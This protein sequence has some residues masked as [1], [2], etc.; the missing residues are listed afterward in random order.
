MRKDPVRRAAQRAH[1][2]RE[3]AAVTALIKYWYL[4]AI[5]G[6]VLALAAAAVRLADE[7]AAHAKTKQGH[8][9]VLRDLADKTAAAYQA[10]LADQRVHKDRLAEL[11]ARHTKELED[12][13]RKIDIA[14]SDVRAGRSRLRV[15]AT[16][17][18]ATADVPPAAGATGM[19]DAA[20]PRLDDAAVGHY[21]ALRRGIAQAD[22]QIAGL[23]A[24]VT[25]VCLAQKK[26]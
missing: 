1:G 15:A 25:E 8:A 17:P 14:E 22:K 10:V 19:D 7:K 9:E 24:Y 21:F 18:G 2:A 23:Q 26:P 5:A 20:G 3:V 4:V 12:A 13:K 16:C 6:L 11:D